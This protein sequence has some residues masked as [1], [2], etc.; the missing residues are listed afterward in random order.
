MSRPAPVRLRRA[1]EPRR[2]A[3]GDVGL[4]RGDRAA[5]PAARPA[6]VSVFLAVRL[7]GGLRLLGRP[8][9][10]RPEA[11]PAAPAPSVLR[12]RARLVRLRLGLRPG[13]GR[14]VVGSR[15]R[16]APPPAALPAPARRRIG[17]GDAR[18]RAGRRGRAAERG[19]GT[20]GRGASSGVASSRWLCGRVAARGVLVH[21][22]RVSPSPAGA[23]AA[24]PD[25]AAPWPPRPRPTARRAGGGASRRTRRR[26]ALR[27][28]EPGPSR[29][30]PRGRGARTRRRRAS[31]GLRASVAGRGLAGRVAAAGRSG[32]R[33]GVRG[34][35]VALGRAPR[36]GRPPVC[37]SCFGRR[38]S[39]VPVVLPAPGSPSGRPA[40]S[41]VEVGAVGGAS[42]GGL[43]AAGAASSAAAALVRGRARRPVRG[44]GL[45]A[46]KL[47]RAIAGARRRGPAVA[48]APPLPGWA[49]CALRLGRGRCR[50]VVVAH[51]Y[52]LRVAARG[53]GGT[54]GVST[55]EPT[56]RGGGLRWYWPG[57]GR[58]TVGPGAGPRASSR[59]RNVLV[60]RLRPLVRGSPQEFRGAGR[61][62]F[63]RLC[64]SLA[65][66]VPGE[67]VCGKDSSAPPRRPGGAVPIDRVGRV[68]VV[69]CDYRHLGSLP[70]HEPAP[71]PDSGASAQVT[72]LKRDGS[73]D[74]PPGP[75]GP[76]RCSAGEG[77]GRGRQSRIPGVAVSLLSTGD[78]TVV[79][80]AGSGAEALELVPHARSP[81]SC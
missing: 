65:S 62:R 31:G 50:D 33:G 14:A 35:S 51:R 59:T 81:T 34:R 1:A 24:P 8:G 28:P 44:T 38:A 4:A 77:A 11:W 68:W 71:P 18:P 78:L 61:A 39:R 20:G 5:R 72:T 53:A 74:F 23:R 70:A 63:A 32:W 45:P 43:G 56:P 22:S 37:G 7:L 42:R 79:G 16:L 30:R 15:G 55:A 12:L 76:H 54:G 13:A 69:R 36:S 9:S 46:A 17:L 40:A 80:Q 49:R 3:G 48:V 75:P 66:A 67:Q 73:R 6:L 47:A 26:S 64:R 19:G 2:A 52:S 57:P 21:E 58:D 60:R 25:P 41:G 29:C 27:R 10:L